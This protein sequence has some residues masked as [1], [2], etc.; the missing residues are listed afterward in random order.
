MVAVSPVSGSCAAR[1]SSSSSVG[2]LVARATGLVALRPASPS[3]ARGSPIPPAEPVDAGCVAGA[4]VA[5]NPEVPS[6]RRS[7]IRF[8]SSD[9]EFSNQQGSDALGRS[10]P[11]GPRMGNGHEKRDGTMAGRGQR[12]WRWRTTPTAPGQERSKQVGRCHASG[13]AHIGE[14]ILSS[15]TCTIG[16]SEANHPWPV[17]REKVMYWTR[18]SCSANSLCGKAS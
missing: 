10:E 13:S 16:I 18:P 15:T 8:H 6:L 4:R 12:P 5:S 2:A 3:V 7:T 17:G 11:T 14:R 9:S 1:V